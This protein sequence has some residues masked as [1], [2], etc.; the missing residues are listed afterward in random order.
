MNLT[1]AN[2]N[3]QI[4]WE[5]YEQLL[6]FNFNGAFVIP[7]NHIKAVSTAQPESSWLDIRNPGSF[8]PGIIKAGSYYSSK[9]KEFWYVT[10]DQH[11]LT[12]E[13]K[14]ES[15]KRIILTIEENQVWLESINQYIS[16][17]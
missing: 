12:L 14:D 3:L 17:K 15:F 10:Q 16:N 7:L 13:L 9:G 4:E 8:I 6:A 1:F 11:Y 5:W 2:E